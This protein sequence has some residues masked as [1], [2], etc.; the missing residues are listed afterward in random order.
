MPAGTLRCAVEN[1]ANHSD[2]V[3]IR[4]GLAM[5]PMLDNLGSHQ[6]PVSFWI[7]KLEKSNQGFSHLVYT[8]QSAL[9]SGD[10]GQV[11]YKL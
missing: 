10:N 5:L 8:V 11:T 3:V 6:K 9:R 4:G 7:M 1:E 2:T